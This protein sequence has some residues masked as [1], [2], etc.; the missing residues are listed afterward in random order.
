[1]RVRADA[2]DQ[3]PLEAGESLLPSLPL[4]SCFVVLESEKI[5]AG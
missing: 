2:I 5:L 1:M 3:I 4:L